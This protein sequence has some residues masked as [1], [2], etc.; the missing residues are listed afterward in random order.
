LR[1]ERIVVVGMAPA[2]CREEGLRPPAKNTVFLWT[3]VA[4]I[5]TK[6]WYAF[7]SLL[8]QERKVGRLSLTFAV[9][10]ALL[11]AG[12]NGSGEIRTQKQPAPKPFPPF[13]LSPLKEY[14][15]GTRCSKQR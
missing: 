13:H 5:R 14:S 9:L 11:V 12:R 15:S 2:K 3:T 8:V 7:Y 10:G 6:K 1:S 4:P